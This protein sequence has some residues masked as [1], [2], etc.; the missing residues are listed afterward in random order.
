MFLTYLGHS[1]VYFGNDNYQVIIDPFLT[2]NPQKQVE[3]AELKVTHVLVT[4]GHADHLGDALELCRRQGVQ[5]I[6]NYEICRY[7]QQFGVENVVALNVGGSSE[8]PFGRVKMVSAIHSSTI[9]APDGQLLPGGLAS[10][11]MIE[12]FHRRLYHAGD[13]ALTLDMKLLKNKKNRIDIAF[14]PVGGTYTMDVYDAIIAT[15][16]LKPKIVIPIHYDTFPEIEVSLKP[17]QRAYAK[18]KTLCKVMKPG[19]TVRGSY[20]KKK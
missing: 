14:L 15:K 10:G 2:G 5:L 8:T 6:A 7:A 20:E 11:Y 17:L 16:W 9:E 18:G 4:H 12:F 1:A 19:T 3:I 13:T